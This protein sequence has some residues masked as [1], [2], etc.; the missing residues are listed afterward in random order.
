MIIKLRL[1][2]SRSEVDTKSN[3]S[4]GWGLGELAMPGRES[5]PKNRER[6]R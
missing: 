5:D 1:K 2:M 4:C 3:R 6:R